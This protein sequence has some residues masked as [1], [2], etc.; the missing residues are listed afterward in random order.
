MTPERAKELSRHKFNEPFDAMWLEC[1]NSITELRQHNSDLEAANIKLG[2]DLLSAWARTDQSELEAWQLK[3][4]LK[5]SDEEVVLL[6]SELG[7]WEAA[8]KIWQEERN[9]LDDGVAIRQEWKDSVLGMIKRIPEYETGEWGGDKE[10]W[11]FCFELIKW[12][13][14]EV[15]KLRKGL[16]EEKRVD[17]IMRNETI[18]HMMAKAE[19]HRD[20]ITK[21]KLE[22]NAQQSEIK[23]LNN[24]IEHA[25]HDSDTMRHAC[26]KRNCPYCPRVDIM[27]RR[28]S[29]DCQEGDLG[30]GGQEG[31]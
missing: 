24:I 13:T 31:R 15:A 9:E 17:G 7:H 5:Q 28:P 1:L 22:V 3:R 23:T 21:L 4:S 27:E 30:Q 19:S 29:D 8:K 12:Q 14:A 25:K 16:K 26:G 11:G 10:G 20:E 18:G 6:R 2:T